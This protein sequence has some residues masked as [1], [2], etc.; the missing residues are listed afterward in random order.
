MGTADSSWPAAWPRL[1]GAKLVGQCCERDA[2]DL[3]GRAH[4]VAGGWAGPSAPF[5]GL[6]GTIA[7]AE[8]VRILSGVYDRVDEWGVHRQGRG[9]LL[10]G[11]E[12]GKFP[13]VSMM[14]K[15]RLLT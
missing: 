14:M 12:P 2:R 9:A 5:A 1:K 6:L 13:E 15:W 8:M 3:L 10:Q 11:Q 4:A 7:P